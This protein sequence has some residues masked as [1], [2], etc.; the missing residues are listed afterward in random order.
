MQEEVYVMANQEYY[1]NGG[2]VVIWGEVVD[3]PDFVIVNDGNDY[4]ELQVTRRK[5]LVKK[6]DSYQYKQA[7]KRAEEIRLKT[8]KAQEN[9]DELS[10]RVVDKALKSLASRI[11]FNVAFG[12]GGSSAAYALMPSEQLQKMIRESGDK[13]A[14][15]EKI[16]FD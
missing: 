15:K 10:E 16:D 7:E 4:G 5:E 11:K 3:K 14:G 2:Y 12:E 1:Y 13:I 8:A 9:L 6:E